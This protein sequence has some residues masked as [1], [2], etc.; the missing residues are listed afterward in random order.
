M[1]QS[2]V[3]GLAIGLILFGQVAVAKTTIKELL[4]KFGRV[5]GSIRPWSL[6]QKIRSN[7]SGFNAERISGS[8]SH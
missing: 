1:K 6:N 7:A 3:L 5:V 2:A 4:K 8:A